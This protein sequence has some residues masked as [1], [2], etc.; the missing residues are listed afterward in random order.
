MNQPADRGAAVQA[1]AV[2]DGTGRT[3][4]REP[5]LVRQFEAKRFLWGDE[6]SG[7]ISDLIYGRGERISA[8]SY[9]LGPGHWFGASKTW[10]PHYDQHRFYYVAAGSLAI[11]D[12]QSGQVEVAS[13]GSAI[14]WRGARYHFG[15]NAGSEEVTVLDWF[16]PPDR[17]LGVPEI[18]TSPAKPE[19]GAVAGG[20]YELLG[21]WPDRRPEVLAA[22][23]AEGGL[24]VVGPNHALHFVHGS[25]RP[26]LVSILSSSDQLTAGTF[27]LVGGSRS[28]PEQHPGDEV[29]YAVSGRLH[30]HLPGRGDWFELNPLD[31]LYIPEGV[32]H[33]YWS[34][35]AG[36]ATAVFCVAPRYR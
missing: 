4:G 21:A 7:Q 27:T 11:H 20:R 34:Y 23:L 31:C 16:A 30:V 10:R 9:A 33:E 17:G 36:P 12:P 1:S 13:R 19:L 8:V 26:L 14:T 25:R 29:V 24:A 2:P 28:E 35:G 5:M 22:T 32:S 3:F 15:Y 18:E 6:E